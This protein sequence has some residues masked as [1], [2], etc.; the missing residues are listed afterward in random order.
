M[1]HPGVG[2][3]NPPR[4]DGGAQACE[5]RGGQVEAAAHLVPTKEH[6]GYEGALHKE[7]QDAFDGKRRTEYIAHE[8]G[9]VAPVRAELKFK[10]QSRGHT[11]GKVNAE[12]FLPE[13]GCLFPKLVLRADILCLHQCH[14]ECEAQGQ[15]NEQPMVAR[16]QGKLRARPIYQAGAHGFKGE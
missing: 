14:D 4:R 10:N 15:G 5:P 3:Q 9:V 1:L 7:G 8:P 2:Y 12:E 11:Y 6:D 13:L 16:R